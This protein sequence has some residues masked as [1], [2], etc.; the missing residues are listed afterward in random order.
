MPRR[1]II[2][3]HV[4]GS[5]NHCKEEDCKENH[6]ADNGLYKSENNPVGDDGPDN[7]MIRSDPKSTN[8]PSKQYDNRLRKC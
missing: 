6:V 2:P 8:V 5:R 4:G 7:W 1:G 3:I